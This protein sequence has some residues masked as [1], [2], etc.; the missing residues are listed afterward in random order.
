L[1]VSIVDA[2]L[3]EHRPARNELQGAGLGVGSVWMNM[4]GLDACSLESF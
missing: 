1:L 4:A 3:A 2:A